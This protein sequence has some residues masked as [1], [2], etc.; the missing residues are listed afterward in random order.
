MPP[1]REP[2]P[3]TAKQLASFAQGQRSPTERRL[4]ATIRELEAKQGQ[5]Y[6]ANNQER[7]DELA[8]A[9]ARLTEQLER[10]TRDQSHYRVLIA[11][12]RDKTIEVFA[13]PQVRVQVVCLPET[14][15]TAEHDRAVEWALSKVPHEFREIMEDNG[16]RPELYSTHC[17]DRTA[18]R[19]YRERVEAW[20]YLTRLDAAVEEIIKHETDQL[21]GPVHESKAAGS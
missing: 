10:L 6:V 14:R 19:Y 21:G 15:T 1:Q 9:N 11:A 18:W 7:L 17:M 5:S 13:D 8:D 4:I 20:G 2:T 16:I 3:F 12:T